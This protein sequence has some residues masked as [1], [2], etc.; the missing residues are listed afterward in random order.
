MCIKHLFSSP[1][2]RHGGHN[3]NLDP[4]FDPRTIKRAQRIQQVCFSTTKFDRNMP[5]S[6]K[7]MTFSF[8]FGS[9]K[10]TFPNKKFSVFIFIYHLN[11]QKVMWKQRL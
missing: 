10:H 3:D 6:K 2:K 8:L 11:C 5:A 4:Q 1:G 7:E 9:D